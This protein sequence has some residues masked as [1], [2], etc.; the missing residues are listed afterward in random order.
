MPTMND[1]K[2]SLY[3]ARQI[4]VATMKHFEALAAVGNYAAHNAPTLNKDDVARMLRDVR[5]VLVK[6]P[7]A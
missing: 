2:D 5:D 3:R 1:Y 7:L 6:H 4:N